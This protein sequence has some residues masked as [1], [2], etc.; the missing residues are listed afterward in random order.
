MV[1]S[2]REA[3]TCATHFLLREGYGSSKRRL[4]QIRPEKGLISQ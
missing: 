4:R 2:V 1:T 3:G